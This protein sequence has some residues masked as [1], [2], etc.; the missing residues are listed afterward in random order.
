MPDGFDSIAVTKD[1]KHTALEINQIRQERGLDPLYIVEIDLV[2][3]ADRGIIS[4]TRIRKGD[5]DAKGQLR[6]PDSMRKELQKPLGRVLESFEIKDS[7]VKQKDNIIVS[8]GDV[9]TETIFL[10]GVQPSLAI[11]D[12]HVE[13]KPYQTLESFKFPKKYTSLRV[14][15]GPGYISKEAEKSIGVWAKG[16]KL[17]KRVVLVVE[18]EEDLLTLPV[19]LAAP[20]GSFVYYGSPP[21]TG[22]EG[23]VEIEVTR[24][25][26]RFVRALIGQFER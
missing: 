12:L 11:I 2:I 25:R 19:I 20:I 23:L 24:E 9:T 3:A 13:R 26:K 14:Q 15:S 7:V 22:K 1:N 10:C 8:V 17:H 4:S 21:S 6:M 5:I 18:G 16:L